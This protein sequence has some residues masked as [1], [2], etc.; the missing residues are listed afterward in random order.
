M[1]DTNVVA[2][3]LLGT[4][5]IRAE[6]AEFWATVSDVFAPASWEAEISNVLRMAVRS[7]VIEL[8]GALYRLEL[9]KALGIRSLSISSL[10]IGALVRACTND[11]SVYDTL[12]VELAER[13]GVLLATFDG[14]LLK[15]F[16]TI[17][18][19]PKSLMQGD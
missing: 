3:Y 10:W 8:S 18:R 11:V 15:K 5:P 12:F 4:E 13:E 14:E 9:V 19:R 6:C 2:Y 7:K 1:A 17:A 16:P